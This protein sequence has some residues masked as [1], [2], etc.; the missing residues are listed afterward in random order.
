MVNAM[1][2]V[3]DLPNRDEILMFC[4]HEYSIQNL[5][6]CAKVDPE[7]PAV[8]NK[9]QEL[10]TERSINH[11]TVPTTIGQETTYNVFMRS[12]CDPSLLQ[13][14]GFSNES[15]TE[16]MKFLREWKNQGSKPAI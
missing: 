12:V 11:W 9:L 13:T 10:K 5:E 8:L 15:H 2:L 3:L 6:F 4:G 14:L 7:N 16:C 1:R